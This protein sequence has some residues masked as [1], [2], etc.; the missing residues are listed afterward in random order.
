MIYLFDDTDQKY[1]DKHIDFN[2]YSDIITFVHRAK[3]SD[4]DV[5][6]HALKKADCIL[7]HRSFR[8]LDDVN[9]NTV[10]EKV[11]NDISNLGYSIPLVIYSDGDRE[12]ADFK[13][14]RF[15]RQIKKLKVYERLKLFLDEYRRSKTI[16]LRILGYGETNVLQTVIESANIIL[17]KIRFNRPEEV[18]RPEMLA[19]IRLKDLIE[20]SQPSLGIS[21]LELL[22]K[23][24]NREVMIGKF[25][26]NI[27]SIVKSFN[28]Y[29]KNLYTWQ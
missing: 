5:Y 14:D 25:R 21:Y 26:E 10:Y 9:K 16:D 3:S 28:N 23:I 11:I 19:E 17:S 7:I 6:E 4:I 29:G 15:L 8:D 12:V 13:N 27:N 1:I 20:R 2:E 24:E 18:L 22:S